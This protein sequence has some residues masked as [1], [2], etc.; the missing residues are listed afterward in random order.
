MGK[1]SKFPTP[2]SYIYT[3]YVLSMCLSNCP[4]HPS[5]RPSIYLSVYLSFYLSIYTSH[6][7]IYLCIYFSPFADGAG[8]EIEVPYAQRLPDVFA[9]KTW[10]YRIHLCAASV[11]VS[12]T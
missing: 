3:L 6:R 1:I 2:Y 8:T 10:N 12:F 4:R 11:V 9:S 5:E 7:S